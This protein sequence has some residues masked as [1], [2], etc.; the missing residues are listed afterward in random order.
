M[1][2]N[3]LLIIT[4]LFLIGCGGSKGDDMATVGKPV[5]TNLE[6]VDGFIE[7]VE[8]FD[9]D[10]FLNK[11]YIEGDLVVI[12]DF[13][14]QMLP[15]N[16]LQ[17][18]AINTISFNIDDFVAG[19]FSIGSFFEYGGKYYTIKNDTISS[20]G[21][22]V[23]IGRVLNPTYPIFLDYYGEY[24]E[25]SKKYE[26]GCLCSE[27][28]N[29]DGWLKQYEIVGSSTIDWDYEA[30]D[31]NDDC[32]VS[33]SDSG[34]ITGTIA[35]NFETANIGNVVVSNNKMYKYLESLSPTSDAIHYEEV[36]LVPV[37]MYAINKYR[38][39]DEMNTTVSKF[40]NGDSLTVS[41]IPSL[42]VATYDALII[43][44]LKCAGSVVVEVLDDTDNTI[45]THTIYPKVVQD[46][47]VAITRL[48]VFEKSYNENYKVKLTFNG[49]GYIG[50]VSLAKS[51]YIGA[52]DIELSTS[53]TDL[54][55]YDPNSTTGF[56]EE[57]VK[58]ILDLTN[59]T[60][61]NPYNKKDDTVTI[62]KML[63]GKFLCIDT[64]DFWKNGEEV[65]FSTLVIAGMITSYD[66]STQKTKK[67]KDVDKYIVTK[68]TVQ[69]VV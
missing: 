33:S 50:T 17:E 67:S 30:R 41:F 65:A 6:E 69:E 45:E 22:P 60:L 10:K 12:D 14:C 35:Y 19:R 46:S 43:A 23:C 40:T 48:I 49:N 51:I 20:T 32:N 16:S 58:P 63:K 27:L 37:K 66:T 34:T 47:L 42:E 9:Y 53:V 64:T 11:E 28:F 54:N 31:H 38:A 29:M 62:L 21:Y 52:T 36:T 2:K 44:N 61:Y 55:S 15:P 4:T 25:D 18:P 13:V 7:E 39:L 1:F 68:L 56:I 57:G 8:P 3:I 26:K 24:N 59:I 5:N